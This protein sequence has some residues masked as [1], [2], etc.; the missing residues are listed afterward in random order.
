MI[1]SS[2]LVKIC[3][4][5]VESSSYRHDSWFIRSSW[6]SACSLTVSVIIMFIESLNF[7]DLF[8]YKNETCLKKIPWLQ[9]ICTTDAVYHDKKI[10]W[11]QRSVN[12]IIAS[13]GS[14][15]ATSDGIPSQMNGFCAKYVC[16]T[17]FISW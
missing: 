3:S 13:F 11:C 5:S 10:L 9:I 12:T 8:L 1:Y 6:N 2:V 17:Q 15:D 14:N 16:I 7:Y 4:K